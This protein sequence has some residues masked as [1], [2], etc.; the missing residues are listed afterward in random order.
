MDVSRFK[1]D[2]THA[3]LRR[4]LC[5]LIAENYHLIFNQNEGALNLLKFQYGTPDPSHEGPYSPKGWLLEQVKEGTWAD[6]LI[7]MA[8]SLLFN[9]K[10]SLVYG[11]TCDVSHYRHAGDLSKADVVIVNNKNIHFTGTGKFY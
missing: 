7:V 6:S 10:L 2:F 11:E 3:H 1:Q 9:L 4:L 5:V 8:F